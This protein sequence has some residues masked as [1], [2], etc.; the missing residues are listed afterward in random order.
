[1]NQIFSFVN[2][3]VGG[4][5]FQTTNTLLPWEDYKARA[6]ELNIK[7]SLTDVL[8]DEIME[9]PQDSNNFLVFRKGRDSDLFSFNLDQ[10]VPVILKLLEVDQQLSAQFSELVPKKTTE[11]MFW[12][13]YFY[14][15]ERVKDHTLNKFAGKKEDKGNM[16]ELHKE[17]MEELE[18]ELQ[19]E[20]LNKKKPPNSEVQALRKDLENALKRIQEL[21][22][23]VQQLE[24][25]PKPE[26]PELVDEIEPNNK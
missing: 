6:K 10:H 3:V 21:E 16:E 4:D 9:L 17:L 1:M 26:D 5:E 22:A 11:E 13:S 25:P 20:N 19:Q 2:K 23:R 24:N 15:V 12:K 14:N 8:R 7:G 18:M